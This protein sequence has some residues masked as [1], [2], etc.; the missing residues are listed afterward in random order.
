MTLQR[1]LLN[2][3]LSDAEVIQLNSG[4]PRMMR[5]GSG[6][7]IIHHFAI[8]SPFFMPLGASRL[9][10]S[11]LVLL[12]LCASLSFISCGGGAKT[13]PPS[14]LTDRVLAS[15]SVTSTFTFGGL[16]IINAQLDTVP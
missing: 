7:V 6:S 15:Q 9:K 2:E 10:R 12:G 13:G 5:T 16:V 3:S 1:K 14:G 4:R 11:I 8:K